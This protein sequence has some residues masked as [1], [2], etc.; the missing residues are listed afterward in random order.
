MGHQDF[1]DSWAHEPTVSSSLP[2]Y[3]ASEGFKRRS[4]DKVRQRIKLVSVTKKCTPRRCL[5]SAMSVT[6]EPL[7]R[8]GQKLLLTLPQYSLNTP[9]S[10]TWT[11]GTCGWTAEGPQFRK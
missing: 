9:H 6:T 1:E 7:A 4:L 2:S 3:A 10:R 5:K 11:C 8:G